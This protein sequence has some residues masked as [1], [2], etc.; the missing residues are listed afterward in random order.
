[1][2]VEYFVVTNESSGSLFSSNKVT[3]YE[4]ADRDTLRILDC[5]C[6]GIC[7]PRINQLI[8]QPPWAYCET[9]VEIIIVNIRKEGGDRRMP[10]FSCLGFQ[11]G[12]K[13]LEP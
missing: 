10:C 13:G 12:Y 1:M 3:P 7:G 8:L 5:Y 4:N 2:L 9:P 6:Q 11:R